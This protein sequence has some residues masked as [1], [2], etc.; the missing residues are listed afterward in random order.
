MDYKEAVIFAAAATSLKLGYQ[1]PLKNDEKD[2]IE[3]INE[4][5]GTIDP[6]IE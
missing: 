4:K 6:K 3:Y 1:G 2:I 5:Y